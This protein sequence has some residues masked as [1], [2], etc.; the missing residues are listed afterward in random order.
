M[1]QVTPLSNPNPDPDP[2]PKRPSPSDP[3]TKLHTLSQLILFS[4]LGTLA[5]LA[6]QEWTTYPGSPILNGVFWANVAGCFVMGVLVE[7]QALSALERTPE[8]ASST[9]REEGH[10]GEDQEQRRVPR[11]DSVEMERG[12]GTSAVEDLGHVPVSLDSSIAA[13]PAAGSSIGRSTADATMDG[14]GHVE[15]QPVDDLDAEHDNPDCNGNIAASSP[16]CPHLSNSIY[17]GLTTGF[18]GCLTSFSS[19]M[20]VVF[21]AISDDLYSSSPCR[22]LPFSDSPSY[23]SDGVRSLSSSVQSRGGGQRLATVMTVLVLTPALCLCA[24]EAGRHLVAG[25]GRLPC[26]SRSPRP[27]PFWPCWV[28]RKKRRMRRGEVF[29]RCWFKDKAWKRINCLVIFLAGSAWIVMV[30]LSIWPPSSILP[31]ISSPSTSSTPSDPSVSSHPADPSLRSTILQGHPAV[32]HARPKVLLP[33]VFAPAGCL[34][35][36]WI[37]SSINRAN[38]VDH[39]LL[40]A[41]H[42]G[43]SRPWRLLFRRRPW[44]PLGTFTVNMLGTLILGVVYAVGSTTA[45]SSAALPVAN[46]VSTD[47][48]IPFNATLS[49][50]ATGTPTKG[51]ITNQDILRRQIYSALQDGLCACL[52]TVSTWVFEIRSLSKGSRS[53]GNGTGR[54]Y[55]YAIITMLVGMVCLV[56]TMGPVYWSG[57]DVLEHADE[58]R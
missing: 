24:L 18:C 15:G 37:S 30:V 41:G 38:T 33:L 11:E 7:A 23:L 52:T 51:L 53:D 13:V 4:F 25:L 36:Y 50:P 2:V 6:F 16:P 8:R 29:P 21:F 32:L 54:A 14:G 47:D 45:A 17:I 3:Q 49:I 26:R 35:R 46:P 42:R 56:V 1:H 27:G 28:D 57:S 31:P 55:L 12:V 9:S 43:R 39:A 48:T 34:L 10:L 20:R 44:F 5:R 40:I 22:L 58:R 19:F